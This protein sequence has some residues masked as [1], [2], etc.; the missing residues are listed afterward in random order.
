MDISGRIRSLRREMTDENIDIYIVPSDDFH[1]S[2]Y[3]G[4]HFKA[5][6]FMTGFT[7]SAGTAV[8]TKDRAGL[9]TDGRYF[10]QAEQE[11]AGSGV[12]LYKAGEPGVDT[13]PE[14]LE[15]ELPDGGVIG[16]DG[17]TVSLGVGENYEKIAAGKGGT[18]RYTE[19]LTRRIWT[20]RPAL[21]KE[22]A[23]LLDMRYSGESTASKLARV[24]GK[25]KEAGAGVHLLSSLDDIAWLLN[26]R[27]NDIA[28]CPLVLS[29]LLVFEDHAELLPTGIN[30][31]TA[32]L[33]LLK[34]STSF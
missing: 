10:I 34:K 5:R 13:I 29:Y 21:P 11:L 31:R 9:W 25:M 24:R 3:V 32:S 26:L 23:W 28:Y 30:S 15:K 8:F 12:T 19:D 2:E 17:R 16:F 6:E 27:G 4:D 14:F 22:K 18:V 20:G 7:G 1:Q 33:L